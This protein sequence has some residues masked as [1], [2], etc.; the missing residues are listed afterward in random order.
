MTKNQK[1]TIY[2]CKSCKRTT[3]ILTLGDIYQGCAYCGSREG[4]QEKIKGR[5]VDKN[6]QTPELDMLNR[7]LGG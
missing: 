1:K 6:Y 2:R 5:W 7:F 3:E 4:F